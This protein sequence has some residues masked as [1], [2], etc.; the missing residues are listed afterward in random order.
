MT[1]DFPLLAAIAA[2]PSHPY[3]I[4]NR[5]RALD[6]P[7]TRSTLYR[8]VDALVAEGLVASRATPG[9]RGQPRRLL[10]LTP[11]GQERLSREAASILANEPLESSRFALAVT[12]AG[13]R[14]EEHLAAVI[15]GRMAAAARRLTREEQTLRDQGPGGDAYWLAAARERAV[16]HLQADIAWM[17]S[18][19]GRRLLVE[20]S[21]ARSLRRAG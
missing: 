12:C 20:R 3:S 15:R 5:L 21:A 18:L 4:L 8:R 14:G 9:E 17:Q 2:T 19:M 1:D 6:V 7:A 16:A 13:L 11:A 10:S